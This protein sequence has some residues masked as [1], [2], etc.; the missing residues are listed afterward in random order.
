MWA[1][2]LTSLKLKLQSIKNKRAN[3]EACF[4]ASLQKRANLSC[5]ADSSGR[6]G[7]H[8]SVTTWKEELEKWEALAGVLSWPTLFLKT[9]LQYGMCNTFAHEF[10]GALL[11]VTIFKKFTIGSFF[12]KC[13]SC[14]KFNS[15]IISWI[16]RGISDPSQPCLKLISV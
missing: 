13:T 3:H 9:E 14:L 8:G 11:S 7:G 6:C 1:S 4:L 16:Q 10:E 12:W 5:R 15:R 2:D